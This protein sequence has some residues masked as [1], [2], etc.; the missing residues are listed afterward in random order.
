VCEPLDHCSDGI[1]GAT[2]QSRSVYSLFYHS[3]EARPT[4]PLSAEPTLSQTS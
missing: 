4:Y 1:F 2:R 3:M